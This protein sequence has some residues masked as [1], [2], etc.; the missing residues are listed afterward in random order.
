[1]KIITYYGSGPIDMSPSQKKSFV[2]ND[3]RKAFAVEFLSIGPPRS[4]ATRFLNYFYGTLTVGYCSGTVTGVGIPV[5]GSGTVTLAV[6][7]N[8]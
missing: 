3:L 7:R 8:A 6:T 5:I 2:N 4:A 1:M